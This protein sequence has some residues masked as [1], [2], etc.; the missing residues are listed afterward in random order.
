MGSASETAYHLRVARDLGFIETA[1][2]DDLTSRVAE[3]RR[4][5]TGLL[6][7]IANRSPPTG[8]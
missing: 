2:C 6:K 4:M 8:H 7:R 5:A 3:V 1:T